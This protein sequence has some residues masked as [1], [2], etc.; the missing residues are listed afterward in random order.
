MEINRKIIIRR[1]V[2]EFSFLCK[3]TGEEEF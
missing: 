3:P 2:R 1:A